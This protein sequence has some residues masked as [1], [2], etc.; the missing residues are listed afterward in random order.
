MVGKIR[1]CL[2][3]RKKH[4]YYTW[5]G[6]KRWDVHVSISIEAAA[7]SI[8]RASDSPRLV[9]RCWTSR[10]IKRTK[11][12]RHCTKPLSAQ[13]KAAQKRDDIEL[14]FEK[15][16]NRYKELEMKP[17]TFIIL[18]KL[19]SRLGVLLARLCLLEQT[20]KFIYQ[21]QTTVSLLR[22]WSQLALLEKLQIL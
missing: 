8:L 14:H 16:D 10:F 22:Q 11:I 7:N 17:E 19:A 6:V 4:S 20:G 18:T 1:L 9:S 15:F 3:S 5:T 13:R 2:L 21:I 12:H